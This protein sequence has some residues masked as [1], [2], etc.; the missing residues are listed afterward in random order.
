MTRFIVT[1]EA[2]RIAVIR[3][4]CWQL[5]RD[6]YVTRGLNALDRVNRIALKRCTRRRVR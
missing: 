4:K 6:G 1:P 3:E 5:I 2:E